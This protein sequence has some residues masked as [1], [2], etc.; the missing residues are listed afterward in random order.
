MSY[1]NNYSFQFYMQPQAL[2]HSH[3]KISK[4]GHLHN[5]WKHGQGD[6]LCLLPYFLLCIHTERKHILPVHCIHYINLH[7]STSAEG[8]CKSA[9]NEHQRMFLK[10]IAN[11][12][13]PLCAKSCPYCI[14]PRL[15][16]SLSLSVYYKVYAYHPTV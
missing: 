15:S 13:N 5:A 7:V 3:S 6:H 14:S 11:L 12:V 8:Q 2:T 16:L 10:Y 9:L 1:F 4:C